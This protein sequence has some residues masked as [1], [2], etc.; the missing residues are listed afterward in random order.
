MREGMP[1]VKAL[2]YASDFWVIEFAVPT[3]DRW[4]CSQS[5]DASADRTITTLGRECI[6]RQHGTTDVISLHPYQT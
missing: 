1:R 2:A 3:R 5:V 6:G 4:R